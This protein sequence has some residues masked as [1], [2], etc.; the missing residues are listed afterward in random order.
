MNW[1]FSFPSNDGQLLKFCD[2]KTCCGI[3]SERVFSSDEWHDDDDDGK[4]QSC[5]DANV[6]QDACNYV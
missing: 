4:L 6:G 5:N 3:F 2:G 1:T